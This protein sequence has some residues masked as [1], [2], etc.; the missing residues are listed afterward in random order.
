MHV[1]GDG[2]MSSAVQRWSQGAA[3][4]FPLHKASW[5]QE[6]GTPRVPP[7]LSGT[8]HAPL[9]FLPGCNLQGTESS[10]GRENKPEGADRE[11]KKKLN[12]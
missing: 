11:Q 9:I 1:P 7:C 6:S 12:K 4:S 8:P 3:T 2:L 5:A 10:F